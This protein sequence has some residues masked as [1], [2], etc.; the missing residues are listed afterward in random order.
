MSI[1]IVLIELALLAF[2][3]F[4]LRGGAKKYT[5]VGLAWWF[6]AL[7]GFAGAGFSGA[8]STMPSSAPRNTVTGLR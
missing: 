5:S 2:I 7:L 6:A 4:L 3:A 8:N 1:W